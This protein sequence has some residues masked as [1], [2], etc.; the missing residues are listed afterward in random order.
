MDFL[1][2]DLPGR[3]KDRIEVKARKAL[4]NMVL[5]GVLK[6]FMAR[7]EGRTIL[8]AVSIDGKVKAYLGVG[9]SRSSRSCLIEV[10]IGT[11]DVGEELMG[12]KPYFAW[13][14]IDARRAVHASTPPPIQKFLL[15]EDLRRSLADQ[16]DHECDS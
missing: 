4:Q 13:D 8:W 12:R 3:F 10:H 6:H 7:T 15:F 14:R 11:W 2:I 9:Q 1:S 5:R 16:P